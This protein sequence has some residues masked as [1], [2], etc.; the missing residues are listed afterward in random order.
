[1]KIKT[2]EMPYKEVEKLPPFTHKKPMKTNPVLRL[3]IKVLSRADFKDTDFT[4]ETKRMELCENKPCFILMNHSCFMD[5]EMAFKIFNDRSFCIVCTSDGFVGKP[6]LMRNLGCIP[7][8]K[9]V[10]DLSL[11]HDINYAIN[12]MNVSVLMYPEASYSFD[13][14]ATPLPRKLGLLMKKLK[15]PVVTVITEGAFHR[16]PLYNCLQK[17]K[18]HVHAKVEC[19]FTPEE[20]EQKSVAEL[21]RALDEKFSFDSFAWQRENKVKIDE[22]FRADGLERILY[23]CPHCLAEGKTKGKG[24]KLRC[25]SCGAEYKL[26]E[27]GVLQSEKPLFSHIPDWYKWEREQVKNE[28]LNSS[29]RL[30]TTVNIGVLRDDKAIYMIGSG[31]LLHTTEGFR[32]ESDDGSLVYTQKPNVSYSLYSDYFWYELGDVICIGTNDTLFYCFPEKGVPVA[33]ARLAT[34]ELY[35]IKKA[36]KA[37]NA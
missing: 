10:S 2:M 25:E 24:I 29:Y 7:T 32:L 31:R 14:C 16:D 21:D 28:L 6:L 27:Y 37:A 1:M 22:P 33:K 13:G 20:L 30:D 34:E 8:N 19:L 11:I 4:Y 12:K 35:K 36:E 23:K 3:L 5:L 17:R 26:D 18:V 9:F 15:A